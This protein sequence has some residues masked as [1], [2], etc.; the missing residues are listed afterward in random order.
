MLNGM[1]RLELNAA[2][3]K[4]AF[5]VPI[6]YFLDTGNLRTEFRQ[7][8]GERLEVY[9]YDYGKRMIWGVTAHII[10]NFLQSVSTVL[11]E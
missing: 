10:R 11:N 7:V 2:E 1:P 8:R 4:E 5:T 6:R 3:V 9:F